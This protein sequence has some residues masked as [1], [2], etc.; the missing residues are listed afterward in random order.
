MSS[1]DPLVSILII[2]YQGAALT[3]DCLV[4]L[5]QLDYANK[6]VIVLD[7]GSAPA[8]R[9]E[10]KDVLAEFPEAKPILHEENLGFAGGNNVA[11]AAA[12][13]S[14]ILLLNNDTVASPG[15]LRALVDYLLTHREVGVVQG[16]M[17]LPRFG[18]T[19]D[20]CGS[21]ATVFG[22]PYHYGY[23]KPDGFKYDRAFPVFGGKGACLLFRREMV[24]R[25]G[26]FLFD[27]D[28]FCYYEETDFCHR[29]WLAGF[30][31]HF[32]PSPPIQHF[33]GGTADRMRQGFA[34][35]H[36]QRNLAFSLWANLGAASLLR[37]MPLFLA[38]QFAAF[39]AAALKRRGWQCRAHWE[40][41]TCLFKRWGKIRER[42][43][44]IA[45]I[46]LCSDREIFAKM[47]RTPRIS[48]FSKTFTGDLANYVDDP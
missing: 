26:G 25:A 24:E 17:L 28:F 8:H 1:T 22:L 27:A 42:R 10:I 40:A 9:K 45:R 15:C 35:E 37:I 16:K 46:R 3:R 6:E 41:L 14:F 34:L 13:G 43:K 18:N 47:E 44:L 12:K 39:L 48:Y 11:F 31:V 7:N 21:F 33:M 19:L 23:Y 38:V 5:R 2:N 36:Y 32:V 4:S 20:V 30:E 29:A